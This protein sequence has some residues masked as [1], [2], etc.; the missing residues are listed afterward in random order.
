MFDACRPLIHIYTVVHDEIMRK[1]LFYC[2][3]STKLEDMNQLLMSPHICV[4]ME[5]K[6]IISL[7]TSI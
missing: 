7:N 2:V 3:K 5:N 6:T 4:K 1:C